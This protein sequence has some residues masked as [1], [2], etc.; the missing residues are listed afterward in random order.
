[1]IDHKQ[2]NIFFSG[3]YKLSHKERIEKL[4][5][6]GFVKN[7]HACYFYEL[8]LPPLELA[9]K[10]IENVLGYFPLPLGVAVN[11]RIDGRDMVI[12]MAV[13][14]TSIIAAASKTAA[15]VNSLGF[16]ETD[17]KGSDSIGQIQCS[18][19]HNFLLF[20]QK[21]KTYQDK[22]IHLAN[23]EVAKGLVSRGGGVKSLHVR[24][25]LRPDGRDM[26]VIHVLIDTCDA[27]GANI[28][29]QV[30]EFLKNPIEQMTGEKVTMC[31]LSNLNDH[32]I[33]RAKVT[34]ENI[35]IELGEK[36]QEA[37][38]FA[39]IDPYRA[40]THNKGILNGIEPIMIA[41][42][43]DWRAVSSGIHAYASKSGS[44]KSI[45][46][47]RLQGNNLIGTLEAPI[48]VGIVG[49][50]TK[51]HPY[52]QCALQILG[53]NS[54]TSLARISAAVGLVQNL[55]ALRALT[56]EGII[57]GHMRLHIDNIIL[58]SGAYDS[59]IPLLKEK[60]LE[61]LALVG[62]ISNADAQIILDA[63]RLK[64]KN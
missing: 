5:E 15:W 21:I 52:A 18:V 61:K 47:W 19:V 45:T 42:G 22:L 59:E 6:A 55:G 26:G 62:R 1:M 13:E 32:K 37:S 33:T 60:L 54:A 8:K 35:D 9:E 44:Y 40:A 7:E 49:G 16:I 4:V 20:E 12:P 11:F 57:K 2:Q 46:Q 43:N 50:M 64:N 14:E 3:F 56:S 38:Y 10:F 29:N 23:Q 63:L 30:C 27:M 51:L 53:I 34:L 41:T 31:I 58:S 28:I 25:L 48:S 17:V 36:I 24:K 39:E